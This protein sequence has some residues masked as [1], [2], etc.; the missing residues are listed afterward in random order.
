[1][2]TQPLTKDEGNLQPVELTP[3]SKKIVQELLD[4]GLGWQD[5][6][7]PVDAQENAAKIPSESINVWRW[8]LILL[9]DD[10]WELIELEDD[11]QQNTEK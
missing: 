4:E 6:I 9:D 8:D 11:Y 10:S 3:D 2:R 1:M 5:I 7:L